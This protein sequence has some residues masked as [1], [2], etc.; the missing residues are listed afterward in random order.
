MRPG[1]QEL[2]GQRAVVARRGG[3]AHGVEGVL[4][5][6]RRDVRVGGDREALRG[7]GPALGARVDDGDEVGVGQRGVDARVVFAHHAEPDDRDF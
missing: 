2:F 3:D 6:K 1:V 5:Q 4:A 7:L